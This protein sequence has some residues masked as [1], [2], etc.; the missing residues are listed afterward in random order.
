MLGNCTLTIPKDQ[1]N[2]E[3]DFLGARLNF[4]SSSASASSLSKYSERILEL[5]A[6]ATLEPLLTTEEF[7]K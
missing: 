4:G 5:M 1:F 2:E 6:N 7:D 3:I